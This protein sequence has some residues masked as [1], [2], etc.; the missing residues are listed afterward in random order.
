MDIKNKILHICHNHYR[1]L[2]SLPN[3]VGVGLGHKWINGVNTLEPCLHV[4]VEN[5]MNPSYI[6][7]QHLIPKAYMGIKTDVLDLE[8]STTNPP[9]SSNNNLNSK[10]RPLEG[11]YGICSFNKEYA[12]GSGT[13]GCIVMKKGIVSN[14]HFIL[15]NYHVLVKNKKKLSVMQP[16]PSGGG[17]VKDKIGT[18]TDFVHIKPHSEIHSYTN[19]VDCAIAK[20][21]SS[22][23]SNKIALVGKV[24]GVSEVSLELKVKKVGKTSGLTHGIVTSIGATIVTKIDGQKATFKDQIIAT[25]SSSPGDSGSV[26]L[27]E[28]NEVVGLLMGENTQGK[29]SFNDINTVFKLLKVELY[30]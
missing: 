30:K 13:I 8:M 21:S 4:L 22:L 26:L 1:C 2:L 25:T 10:I 20:I 15:S 18:V 16:P 29:S 9:P 11:G 28:K 3:V 7:N 6:S 19:Y 14:D 12:F 5:K 27:N 23:K 17:S 24:T